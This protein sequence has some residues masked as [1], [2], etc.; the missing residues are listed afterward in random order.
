MVKTVNIIKAFFFILG[1]I[2]IG[3]ITSCNKEP[4]YTPVSYSSAVIEEFWLEKTES[5]PNLNRPYQGMVVGDSAI[6]LLVDYGTDI[7]ALEPTIISAADSM[8]P[9]GKQNFTNPVQYTL[10]ANGKSVKY[11]IRIEVSRVQYP[12]IKSIAAGFSHI[13]AIKN[14]G[15]VWVCGNNFS[16]QLGLGDYSSRN[17]FTQ[18]PFYEAEQVITGDAATFIRMKDGAMWGAG[19]QYGQLGLGHRRGI[20]NFSR[21]PFLDDATEIAITFGEV[22]V[23]KPNGSVYGAGRNFGNILAQADADPRASFVKIPIDNVK[24][25]SGCASDIV[26]QKTNGEIWG[27]GNNI[28]GQLGFGDNNPRR[29]PVRLPVSSIAITKVFAGGSNIFLMDNAGKIW[30]SGGNTSGQLAVG[31]QENRYE[32]TEVAFFNN[33]SVDVIIPRLSATSFVET[34]GA[35]WNAGSNASGLIGLGN[36]SSLPITT[37]VQLPNLVAKASTGSGSTAFVLKTDGTLWAWGSNTSGT[38]GTGTAI[39]GVSSPIQIK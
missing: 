39:S 17:V 34:N 21:V 19:N 36:S 28:A 18:V 35:I 27:W 31:D 16:G 25:I 24:S 38:L 14:D 6:R 4:L 12:V 5:N 7:T 23:L 2:A 1:V 22:F 9:R 8:S 33:K 29:T 3:T 10:W 26:V 30:A 13:I 11:S 32:F 20:A 37:P 15:T